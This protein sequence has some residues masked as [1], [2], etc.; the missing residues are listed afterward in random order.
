M[1]KLHLVIFSL[2]LV[3]VQLFQLPGCSRI[4]SRGKWNG[5]VPTPGNGPSSMWVTTYYGY[6]W[7]YQLP[8]WKFSWSSLTHVVHFVGG[9]NTSGVYPYFG[10]PHEMELGADGVH[11]QDSLVTIAHRHGVNVLMDLGLNSNNGFDQLCALGD[12][13]IQ[14]WAHTVKTHMVEK[15]YDG[16]D[17]DLEP[18]PGP[19]QMA[20]WG[21]MLHYLRDT[22]NTLT[23]HGIVTCAVMQYY[24]VYFN[25][26]SLARLCDQ[27][28]LMEYDQAGNWNDG[29]GYNSPLYKNG[30][31]AGS[32][33]SSCVMSWLSNNGT[34]PASKIGLGVALYGRLFDGISQP[35]QRPNDNYQYRWYNDIVNK[36]MTASGA[37]FL[38]DDIAQVPHIS[39][40]GQNHWL[41]YDN[42]RS[43]QLKVEFAKRYGL[44][45][46]MTFGIGEGYLYDAPAGRDPNELMK[47]IGAAAGLPEH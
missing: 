17:I 29:A 35:N 30:D 47:A 25:P 10:L 43:L 39:D 9:T 5:P 27:I 4:N 15:G 19:V 31:V 21:K 3:T 42:T 12:T 18:R 2:F 37:K 41:T 26:D 16:C 44:G 20:G 23:P 34:I 7:Q 1:K 14:T 36:D 8:P 24:S 11:Y 33:D 22:M 40:P 32:D 13:A 46:I 45:G 28:N 6:W 38:W